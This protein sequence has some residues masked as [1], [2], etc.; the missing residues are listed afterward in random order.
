MVIK[1]KKENSRLLKETSLLSKAKSFFSKEEK[2]VRTNKKKQFV[3]FILG[4]LLSYL[5]ITTIVGIVPDIFYKTATGKVVES[6]LLIQGVKIQELGQIDCS[7][8]SWVTDTTNGQCYSFLANPST[9]GEK[10]IIISW[11]CTGVLE[12]IILISAILASFGINWKKK[13]AGIGIAIIAGVIF[14]LLRILITV[15]F[16]LTQSGEIV[17]LTHD[18]LFRLVL[19]IY[20]VVVYVLWF[21][22]SVK[23]K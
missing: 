14:N 22:W 6:V 21:N 8:F 4:F 17:E 15:N 11:L 1:K 19:F 9:S 2:E 20:I 10:Q 23:K 5:I 3:F 7:E 16:I 12:I 13:I 18:V